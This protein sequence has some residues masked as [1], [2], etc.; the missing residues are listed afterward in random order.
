M[1]SLHGHLCLSLSLFCEIACL[2]HFEKENLVY[3]REGKIKPKR[4]VFIL[5][6]YLKGRAYN[7]YTQ[8]VAA[9][10]IELRLINPN[11]GLSAI[12]CLF[13]PL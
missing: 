1:V 7:Y 12:L 13:P 6:Y 9:M 8:R 3:I 2:Y 5:S 10:E 4:Q 11:L